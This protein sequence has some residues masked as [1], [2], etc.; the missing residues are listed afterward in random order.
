MTS[1]NDFNVLMDGFLTLFEENFPNEQVIK[2]YR[3]EFDDF[4]EKDPMRFMTTFYTIIAPYIM[5]I[6]KKEDCTNELSP[7][8]KD[9]LYQLF[10]I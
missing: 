3:K 5:S 10:L 4:R 7:E 8:A 1:V 9:K 2:K 6:L